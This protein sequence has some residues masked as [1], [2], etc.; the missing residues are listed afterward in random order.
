MNE[1]EL[2]FESNY[3]IF[4]NIFSYKLASDAETGKWIY[5][6]D[7]NG[8]EYKRPFIVHNGPRPPSETTKPDK[9]VKFTVPTED[10]RIPDKYFCS[11]DFNV[12]FEFNSDELGQKGE[13]TIKKFVNYLMN[14]N[15][16]SVRVTGFAD[17]QGNADY[18]LQLSRKRASSVGEIMQ[19]M[20]IRNVFTSG[21]GEENL[22]KDE[23]GRE[24]KD[25][26]RRVE[27]CW[28]K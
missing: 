22:I 5:S 9:F 17:S 13:E 10:Q 11:S 7:L 3:T 24:I 15:F 8:M 12:Q 27:F 4:P 2:N 26:S 25:K 6:V 14:N 16:S 20:G 18:N 19:Q 21:K 23:W 1:D 28:R